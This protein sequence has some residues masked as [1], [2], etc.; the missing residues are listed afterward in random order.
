[1][2]LSWLRCLLADT[3]AFTLT[4]TNIIRQKPPTSVNSPR[5]CTDTATCDENWAMY[6]ECPPPHQHH[7]TNCDIQKQQ[8]IQHTIQPQHDNKGAAYI[9]TGKQ[10]LPPGTHI[11]PFTGEIIS[12]HQFNVRY[13]KRTPTTPFYTLGLQNGFYID[14]E[15]YG[16][17]TRYINNSCNPNS[18]YE[19]W[20]VNGHQEIRLI[21][22]AWINPGEEVTIN[23]FPHTPPDT[24]HPCYCN[25]PNCTGF[26]GKA[27]KQLTKTLPTSP[28]KT[29]LYKQQN[30]PPPT[31]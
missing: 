17:D 23:Y 26:M 21:T 20:T 14:A 28:N 3:P 29:K 12:Q 24:N 4:T 6:I 2:S 9:Y 31:A 8:E 11:G 5:K 27:R 30:H 22:H 7:C 25:S 1:M 19:E 16:N 18:K 15:K 10:P 13:N